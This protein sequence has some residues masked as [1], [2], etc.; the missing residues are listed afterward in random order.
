MIWTTRF[1]SLLQQTNL[2]IFFRYLPYAFILFYR[3]CFH[4]NCCFTGLVENHQKLR[5]F[6]IL[7]WRRWCLVWQTT[8]V[9]VCSRNYVV[10]DVSS[11]TCACCSAGFACTIHQWLKVWRPLTSG[12][13]FLSQIQIV[14]TIRGVWWWASPFE[15]ALQV[16][17][18][19]ETR[20]KG[21]RSRRN[22]DGPS[23][24]WP[25]DTQTERS[26]LS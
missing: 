17:G 6:Q 16:W 5:M 9:Y 19:K 20:R 25:L 2:T 21:K 1:S 22:A 13:S 3:E 23:V 26:W 8:T 7:L 12:M 4:T 18:K 10:K 14:R 24:K 15:W 11:C